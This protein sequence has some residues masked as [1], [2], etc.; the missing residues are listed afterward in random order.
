MRYNNI[1]RNPVSLKSLIKDGLTVL[2]W[3]SVTFTIIV[4][5]SVFLSTH[6]I[7]YIKFLNNY[8][9]LQ[10][11]M[12]ITFFLWSAKFFTYGKNKTSKFTYSFI[13]MLLSIGSLCFTMLNVY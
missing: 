11:S 3:A 13:C 12:S 1:Y 9:A 7:I 5:I 8:Y 6:N 2:S 10:I 4:L